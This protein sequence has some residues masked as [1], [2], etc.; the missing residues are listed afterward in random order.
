[1][2]KKEVNEFIERMKEADDE[3]TEDEVT[4]SNYID[5]SL[6]EATSQRLNDLSVMAN[7]LATVSNM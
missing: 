1:M 5:M 2:T 3:W 4:G 7:I 6:E